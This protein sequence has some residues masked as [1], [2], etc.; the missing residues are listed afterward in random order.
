MTDANGRRKIKV[1]T[2]RGIPKGELKLPI[3]L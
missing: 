2:D 1:Y 3:N